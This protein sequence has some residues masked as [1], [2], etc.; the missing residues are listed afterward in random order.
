MAE[1]EKSYITLR[2]RQHRPVSERELLIGDCEAQLIVKALDT[3]LRMRQGRIR[4]IDPDTLRE[5]R[6]KRADTSPI[7]RG[8]RGRRGDPIGKQGGEQ[9]CRTE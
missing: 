8:C 3:F 4:I 2:S 1:G 6:S 7:D 5:R 9:R